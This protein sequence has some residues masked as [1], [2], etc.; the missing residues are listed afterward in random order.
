MELSWPFFGGGW[1][2]ARQHGGMDGDKPAVNL[3]C[4]VPLEIPVLDNWQFSI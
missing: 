3:A 2:A 1:S 4:Q